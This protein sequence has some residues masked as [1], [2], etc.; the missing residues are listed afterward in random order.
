MPNQAA[1]VR[2]T[3]KALEELARIAT[4]MVDG[5]EADRI[6]TARAVE[7]SAS[8]D[9]AKRWL[10][11]GDFHDVDHAT[12]LRMKKTLMR[13]ERLADFP[14]NASLWVRARGVD[15]HVNLAIQNGTIHRYYE[16]RKALIP[17]PPEMLECV[18]TGKIVDAPE[19]HPTGTLTVLAPVFDSLGDVLAVVELSAPHP[20]SKTLAPAWS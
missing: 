11:G 8:P 17:M 10:G 4:A 19:E 2:K 7:Y 9:P 3:L 6:L 12:F 1:K 20:A 16:F 5:E 15:G 14:C 13:L 18:K